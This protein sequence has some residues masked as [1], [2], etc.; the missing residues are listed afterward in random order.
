MGLEDAV[1]N[2]WSWTYDALGRMTA[3]NDPDAGNWS[4]TYDD[5][6]RP[7]TQ[8]DA[9]NQT[10]SFTYDALMGRQATKVS[11]VG[12]TTFTYSQARAGFLQRGPGDDDLVARHDPPDRPRRPGPPGEAHQDGGRGELRLPEA[13]DASGRVTGLTYPDGDEVGPV[14][15]PILYD[16]AGRIRSVPGIV[17]DVQYD[18]AGRPTQRTNANG[19]A[20]TMGFDPDRGFL[21][22]IY[23]SGPAVVQDLTYGND[24]VGLV[25]QVTSP[26]TNDA[27][28]YAY[29][30]LYRLTTA[31]NLNT[32]ANS[33]SWSYDSIGRITYNSRVGTYTYPAA[34]QPRPHAPRTWPAAATPTTPTAI[35]RPGAAA[36]R[37]GTRRTASRRWERPSSATMVS[38]RGSRRW[39]RA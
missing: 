18:A 24:P 1:G 7:V 11:P 12:T 8:V 32:P 37:P 31:T 4:Y 36:P 34:G 5:A 15:N 23:T 14:G 25:N 26:S 21:E 28:S 3:R 16:Q 22:S 2:T 33:Q 6:G 17:N 19:T 38:E 9:K 20:T 35:S 13:F 10:T 27:W 29:D 30:D 39:P